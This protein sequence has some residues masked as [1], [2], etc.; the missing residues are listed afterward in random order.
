MALAYHSLEL[1]YDMFFPLQFFDRM[2][3]QQRLA[4]RHVLIPANQNHLFLLIQLE[5]EA[6]LVVKAIDMFQDN[7]I[8]TKIL[9]NLRTGGG[10]IE[11]GNMFG[12]GGGNIGAI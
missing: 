4:S 7:K 2:E 9:I 6:D 11:D 8:N 3:L 10:G 1:K 5:L 12:G